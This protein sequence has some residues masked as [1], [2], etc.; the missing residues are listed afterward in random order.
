MSNPPHTQHILAQVIGAFVDND[1]SLAPLADDVV[2]RGPMVPEPLRGIT[3]VRQHLAD[4]APFV[5]RMKIKRT[6][7]EGDSIAVVLEYESVNGIVIEGAEFF[8][9]RDGLIYEMQVFFDTRSLIRAR[10]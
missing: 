3:A 5:A 10:D 9:V 4:I 8:R 2:F 7:V 1:A 6:V